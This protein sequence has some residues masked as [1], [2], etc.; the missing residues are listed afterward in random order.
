MYRT[1]RKILGSFQGDFEIFFKKWYI[2]V[3]G[4]GDLRP[5]FGLMC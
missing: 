4:L 5:D 1:Y 3:K 2:L